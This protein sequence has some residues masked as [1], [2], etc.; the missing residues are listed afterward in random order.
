MLNASRRF[1]YTLDLKK[2][3]EKEQIRRKIRTHAQV[4]RVKNGN[5]TCPEYESPVHDVIFF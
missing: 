5:K 4:I 2:E 1:R 3:G